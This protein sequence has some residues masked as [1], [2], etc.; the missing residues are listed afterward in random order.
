M[1]PD[2][3]DFLE[4]LGLA[5]LAL[6][7]AGRAARALKNYV[8]L[9]PNL[10]K[11]PDDLKRDFALIKASGLAG[12]VAEIYGGNTAL[13]HSTR[14]PVRAEWL[15][16]ALPLAR[17]EGL[18]VHA[19]MWTMICT[20]PDMVRDHPD[21]YNVNAKGESASDKPAYVDYYKFLDPARPEVR[22]F[23][24][25]TVTEIASIPG[26]ASVHLD[27]VRHPDAILPSGLW[28]KYGIVQDRVYPPYDYGYTAYSRRIFK[29]THGIDP[30][31]LT[32]PESNNAWMQYRLDS[33]VDLVNDYLVP[34]AHAK[35]TKITAAV[36]PGPSRARV[37]VRQ[38]WGRF[39]L[40]AFFP[41]LYHAFYDAGPEFVKQYTRRGRAHGH[42]AGAQRPLRR[43]ARRR[44]VHDDGRDGHLGGR[45]GRVGLRLRRDERRALAA[46]AKGR[47]RVTRAL[48]LGSAALLSAV[49]S[50]Q[51]GPATH[52]H[53]RGYVAARVSGR[54]VIDGRLDDATWRTAAWS[55]AFVD[56]EGDAKPRPAWPT[57]VKMAWDDD[58]LYVGAELV[59]PHVWATLTAH[60][61]V[62]FHD[63]DFEVFIDPDADNRNY[64]ELEINALG[65]T[66]DLRLPKPYRD[67]GQ[68][69]T[70]WEIAGLR[71]AVSVDGT[72]NDAR[73][74]DRSWSV[75]LALPWTAL[76]AGNHVTTPPRDGDQ[77]RIN[78]SRVEWTTERAGA[79]Y[80]KTDGVPEHN[81]VWSP[82][83]AIDM[84]R[85]EMWG[86]VQFS[87]EPPGAAAFVPD[88][89]WPARAWLY[90]AYYAQR[91][92]RRTHGRYVR[93]LDE[94]GLALPNGAG[95]SAPAL[96]STEAG[97]YT[98][99]VVLTLP[100][101]R[102]VRCQVDQD[103]AIGLTALADAMVQYC[104]SCD[105]S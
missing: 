68:A 39:K 64:S 77:W 60:D 26:V 57:R 79:G 74:V 82:Q 83:G 67:G 4:T 31:E 89:T 55:D 19:W 38:D 2:R 29:E 100:G 9:R 24:R 21:W 8:W 94:F 12:I 17:A 16:T 37:M 78:F 43:A 20:R 14:L 10:S 92:F 11:T 93:T 32:D 85:P 48:A 84:H 69:D 53:P 91:E 75:E 65:T 1:N 54:I 51:P 63:N 70:A 41:M 25:D 96:T 36:F 86:Y 72:P 76:T 34:A 6:P 105:R 46:A 73:D 87:T 3:R 101:G 28:S 50:G 98:I 59:E 45:G 103:S 66:W 49:I 22:E 99:S 52:P 104:T 33:V 80:R 81:W 18:E 97:R 47:H 5:A 88:A 56:I 15:E 23:I 90:D 30:I 62:I 13:F 40:D 61:A 7:L 58:F 71:S 27:Y 102:R 35:G 95:L 42:G 44:R